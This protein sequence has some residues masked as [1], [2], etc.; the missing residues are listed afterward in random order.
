MFKNVSEAYLDLAG[1]RTRVQISRVA[2]T[3]FIKDR[4]GNQLLVITQQGKPQAVLPATDR[5]IEVILCAGLRIH[6]YVMLDGEID[7]QEIVESRDHFADAAERVT[8]GAADVR[9]AGCLPAH[10]HGQARGTC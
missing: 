1:D 8:F 7:Y 5:N 2:Q 6:E 9:A 4:L 10:A 3:L